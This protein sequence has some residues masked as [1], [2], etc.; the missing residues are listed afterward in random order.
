M[1]ICVF[2]YEFP[3][4]KTEYGIKAMLAAGFEISAV[5]AQEYKSLSVPRSKA[6][7]APPLPVFGDLRQLCAL[8]NIPLLIADHDSPMAHEMAL[9]HELTLGVILGARI[10]K[11]P[12]I[13]LFEEGVLNIHPGLIPENRGLDNFKWSLLRRIQVANTAHLIDSKIDL[14]RVL[15]ISKTPVMSDDTLASFYYR[16]FFSEFKLLVSTLTDLRQGSLGAQPVRGTGTYFSAVP[17]E[18]D[19]QIEASFLDYKSRFQLD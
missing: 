8:N 3:H 18:L 19:T 2:A 5:I 13:D 4:F 14:G 10:L 16:H 17:L 7:L 11:A 1:K 15:K 9:A 6:N 12:T